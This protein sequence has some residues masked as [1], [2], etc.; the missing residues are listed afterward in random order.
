M[1]IQNQEHTYPK[2]IYVEMLVNYSPDGTMTPTALKWE[3]GHVY[4]IDRVLD[5]RRAASAAGSMGIRYTVR[6]MGRERRL[7]YED[8]YST[9]GQPRWFV[10][11]KQSAGSDMN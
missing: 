10:E 11:N 8:T 2:R 5:V 3:D 1:E 7:F 9:T 4:E 6:I